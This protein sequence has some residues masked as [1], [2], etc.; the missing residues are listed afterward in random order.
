MK[1]LI[2][3]I[4]TVIAI[5]YKL[6]GQEYDTLYTSYSYLNDEM[7]FSNPECKLHNK[8]LENYKDILQLKNWSNYTKKA[9]LFGV[10]YLLFND[11]S[12]FV[13][14]SVAD[15]FN[16]AFTEQYLN[17]S[18]RYDSLLLIVHISR[19]FHPQTSTMRDSLSN[20]RNFTLHLYYDA[21]NRFTRH[22]SNS[23][24]KPEYL[25]LNS[26]AYLDTIPNISNGVKSVSFT[27]LNSDSIYKSNN[28]VISIWTLQ[29]IQLVND[30][31]C[32]RFYENEWYK[33][34]SSQ[35]S[36]ACLQDFCVF[37]RFDSAENRFN[38]EATEAGGM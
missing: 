10:N 19:E 23:R 27:A 21:F 3:L 9:G 12:V 17:Q 24:Y 38:F 31:I 16:L 28:N 29:N 15:S 2:L 1:N 6:F 18:N 20:M 33:L 14:R 4:L 26:N 34:G 32:I 36:S 5:H 8:T 30:L 35:V 25:Y 37:Y 11:D 13:L 22:I 7:T